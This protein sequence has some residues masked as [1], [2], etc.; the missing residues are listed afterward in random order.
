MAIINKRWRLGL[1]LTVLIACMV[2]AVALSPL[3]LARRAID[4]NGKQVK[5]SSAATVTIPFSKNL[6]EP[7]I[8]TVH[9]G[10]TVIW[11]NDDKSAHPFTTT[12]DH[13]GF[14]NRQT[15][16]F[17]VASGKSV[18]FTFTKPGLYHYFETRL[19]TWNSVFS[20]VVAGR[21][22]INFPLSM[23]GVIWVQGP[24]ANLTSIAHNFVLKGH[25]DFASE[26]LAI[27]RDGAVTWH[28]LDEDTHFVGLVDG[29][30]SPVNPVDIGLYRLSGT[31]AV[32]GGEFATV[33]FNMPGLY[34]YYCRNH[35]V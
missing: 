32:P 23:E 1:L 27:S 16:S 6:F 9:L 24:L 14:L 26:F 31:D 7:F 35:D 10:T 21:E 11:Q 30:S 25:D 12:P 5:F 33:L 34:Y 28:N 15:F 3:L 19:D 13:S 22:K 4:T 29:W 2:A 18:R 17:N 20:R 8:L